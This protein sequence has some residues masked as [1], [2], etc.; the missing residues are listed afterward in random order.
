MDRCA[1]VERL[2]AALTDQ[3][4][5]AQIMNRPISED[6]VQALAKAARLLHDNDIPWPPMLTQVLD[7]LVQDGTEPEP[8]QEPSIDPIDDS[9]LKGLSRFLDVF[10]A[11]SVWA[12]SAGEGSHGDGR[13]IQ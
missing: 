2:T 13:L 4:L 1:E 5:D 12:E 10:R 11:F 9:A 3:I 8:E 7:E 6:Q